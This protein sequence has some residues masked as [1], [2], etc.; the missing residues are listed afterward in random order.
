MHALVGRLL[1]HLLN[2]LVGLSDIV[3]VLSLNV[4]VE[5]SAPDWCLLPRLYVDSPQR[6][7]AVCLVLDSMQEPSIA[8]LFS[9]SKG[10]VVDLEVIGK[11]VGS[12]GC[13]FAVDEL[14]NQLG[15]LFYSVFSRLDHFVFGDS[16]FHGANGDVQQF[17]GGDG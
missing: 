17:F 5:L 1:Q 10:V 9:S 6:N 2:L 11:E 15:D 16:F 7:L 13:S 3:L 8:G 14:V 12:L 4:Q